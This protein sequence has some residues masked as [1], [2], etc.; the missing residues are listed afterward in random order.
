MYCKKCKREWGKYA[1]PIKSDKYHC[2][3]CNEEVTISLN[4]IT[5][6]D[7]VEMP[8]EVEDYCLDREIS[9]HCQN[10]VVHIDNDNN[11]F[12][13]WLKKNGYKFKNKDYDLIA[14]IAT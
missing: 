12:A 2:K 9:T 10:E 3:E 5:C 1:C 13:K 7:A 4:S 6:V 11:P 8:V 14:I